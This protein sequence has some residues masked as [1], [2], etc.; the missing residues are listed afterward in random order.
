MTV[1]EKALRVL[2]FVAMVAAAGLLVFVMV[3][4]AG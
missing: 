4:T 3:R 1:Y 2:E